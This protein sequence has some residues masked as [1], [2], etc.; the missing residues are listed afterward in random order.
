MNGKKITQ[1]GS[2]VVESDKV[3]YRGKE[4]SSEKKVYILMNKPKD[5]ITTVS[6]PHA[7]KTVTDLVRGKCSER[8]F[9]VG[10]LDRDT[11]GVLLLTN[12]GDLALKLTHP[13]YGHRKIYHVFLDKDLEEEHRT[14]IAGGV[15]LDGETVRPDA[16]DFTEPGDRT[17]VGIEIHSG[18]NRIVRRIFESFGY[19]IRKLDRVYFAG[20]TKK[21]LK[22]GQWRY[23]TDQEAG[24][25]KMISA[26]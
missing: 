15:D 22:R 24:K 6:D 16:I 19:R 11:T 1:L 9:P 26:R 4:L 5:F 7:E 20:M 17:Q 25:L 8:V 12:D 3:T 23:L 21:G 14:A 10:R 2:K 13:R 18:Q